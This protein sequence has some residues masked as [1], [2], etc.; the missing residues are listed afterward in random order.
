[1][2][3]TGPG[4][5]NRKRADNNAKNHKSPS[6]KNNTRPRRTGIMVLEPRMM[7]DAAAAATVA[8]TETH[9]DAAADHAVVAAAADKQTVAVT[10]NTG[11]ETPSAAASTTP[12]Q[13]PN[14]AAPAAPASASSTDADKATT[15]AD[16]SAAAAA[17]AIITVHELV[18]IDSRVDDIETLLGGVKA[19]DAVLVL[20]PTKDGVQQIADAIAANNLH[21]LTAIQI[22]SHGTPGAVDLGSISLSDDNLDSHAAALAAMGAALAPGG[23]IMLWG[24]DVAAGAT[25]A[26]FIADLS[27]HTGGAHVAAS[28]DATGSAALGG[29][30]TLE[31]KTGDIDATLPFS[32]ATRDAYTD[33]L[34]N[35]INNYQSSLALTQLVVPTGVFP[36]RDTGAGGGF[37][38]GTIRTFAGNF[39]IGNTYYAEGQIENINQNTA[40]FSLLGTN[41]GGDGRST[42]ALPDLGGKVMIGKGSVANGTD[43]TVGSQDGSGTVLLTPSNLLGAGNLPFDNDQP[44]LTITYGILADGV[45]PNGSSGR[46]STQLI[47]EVV[48]FAGSFSPGAYLPC[49][50]R[51]VPISQYEGLYDLIGNMYGGSQAEGTFGLP[52]LQGRAIMG[53]SSDVPLGTVVGQDSVTIAKANLPSSMGGFQAPLDNRQPSLALNYIIATEGI[54]PSRESGDLAP[55]TAYMGEVMAFAGDIAHIPSGWMLADGRALAINGYQALFS[56]LG[57]TYGGNGSTNFRLPDLRNHVVIGVDH[58][59]NIQ[60][61]QNLGS[62]TITLTTSTTPDRAPVLSVPASITSVV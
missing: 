48:A 20:D 61:G 19:G 15:S 6:A 21:D 47:G 60:V 1:M 35:P 12:A 57:T 50:G 31:A 51:L 25:G 26:K 11:A 53:A 18:V 38:I 33:L 43:G 52:D 58:D 5:F 39:A 24:C 30:W 54:F 17:P 27:A 55:T 22:I 36:S 28:T 4:W 62:D 13:A 16:T 40:L 32:D 34:V 42:Y 3:E 8:A 59:A 56:L 2:S 49:D 10:S 46:D 14:V 23:D 41:Y 9:Q 44:S 7:Y 29:N 37:M 45:F